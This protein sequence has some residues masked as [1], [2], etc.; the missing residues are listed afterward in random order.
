MAKTH[1]CTFLSPGLT[2]YPIVRF[3]AAY[4]KKCLKCQPIT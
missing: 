4:S 3:T 1:Y 2:V